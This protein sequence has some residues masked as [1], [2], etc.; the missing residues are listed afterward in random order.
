MYLQVTDTTNNC[1]SID[2]LPVYGS[3]QCFPECEID[4][5]DTLTCDLTSVIL[6][7]INSSAGAEFSY[8][9]STTLGT[10]CSSVNQPTVCVSEN[11]IYRLVITNTD[12]GLS[13]VD[14]VEVPSDY[15]TPNFDVLAEDTINCLVSEVDAF[16]YFIDT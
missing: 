15:V 16:F 7:A 14:E 5:P 12:T 3:G 9:W 1:I 11:E 6:T 2:S 10:I 8:E 13:C 4:L